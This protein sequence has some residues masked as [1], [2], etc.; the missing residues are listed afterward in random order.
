L[1]R[2]PMNKKIAPAATALACAVG[3]ATPGEI[4]EVK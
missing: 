4:E 2:N 1:G 3:L